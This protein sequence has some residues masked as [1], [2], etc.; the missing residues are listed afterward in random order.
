MQKLVGE[1]HPC[2]TKSDEDPDIGHY[3]RK[4]VTL[5]DCSGRTAVERRSSAETRMKMP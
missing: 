2:F 5:S 1:P 3:Y 4:A